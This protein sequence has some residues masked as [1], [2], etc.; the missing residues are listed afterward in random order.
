VTIVIVKTNPTATN[1]ITISGK[2]SMIG[3]DLVRNKNIFLKNEL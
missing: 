3:T 1:N 2:F